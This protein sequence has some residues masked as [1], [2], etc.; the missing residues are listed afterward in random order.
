MMP[1]VISHAV[2]SVAAGMTFGPRNV[3][4]HFWSLSFICSTISDLDSIAFSSGIPY[5][6]FFGHRGFFRSPFFGLLLGLF[7]VFVFFQGTEPFSRG[8]FFCLIFFFLL[9]A[10]HGF[11]DALTNGGLGVALWSPFDQTRYFLP[12][13]PIAV[14]PMGVAPFFSRWGLA[15]IKSELLWV[16]LPCFVMVI[17]SAI[18]RRLPARS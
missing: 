16:W 9:A 6:H 15:V 7:F 18:I 2:V 10:S 8:W 12:W 4:N 3:P 5:S 1:S 13:R 17:V 11:L 14:S